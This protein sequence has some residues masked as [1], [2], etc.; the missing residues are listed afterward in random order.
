MPKFPPIPRL[1]IVIPVGQDLAAFE[2]TLVSVLENQP[3]G[4][5]ILVVHD[6]SYADPFELR[7]EVEFVTGDSARLADLVAAGATAARGRF[8]HVLADGIRA[9]EGWVDQALEKFE[10]H[11][12]GVATPVI[13]DEQSGRIIAAGWQDNTSGLCRPTA[14]GKRELSPATATASQSAYLQAS[15]WRRDLLRSLAAALQ[16]R[17][18]ALET[19]YAYGCLL[20][21]AGWRSVVARQCTL[22]ADAA[23]PLSGP[24]SFH[25]GQRL[26]AIRQCCQESGGWSA[27]LKR[28]T[29]SLA[30]NLMR[31]SRYTESIGQAFGPLVQTSVAAHIDAHAVIDCDGPE[32]IVKLPSRS[33]YEAIRHAA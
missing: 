27:A 3:L 7:D 11:D 16:G 20:Q 1:S 2:N 29:R 14:E 32:V 28:A 6:G 24:A 12:A 22:L 13:R 21:A 23:G 10:H 15:F 19:S 31:P 9:T 8:V 17:N 26:Q 4:C 18:S 30:G 25:R 5:E 33:N